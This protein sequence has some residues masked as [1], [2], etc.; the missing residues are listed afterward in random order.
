MWF[1]MAENRVHGAFSPPASPLGLDM[2]VPKVQPIGKTMTINHKGI[3][4]S[5][6]ES[7]DAAE[8]MWG[9]I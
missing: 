4:V 9:C 6:K 1:G 5:S 8:K 7:S 2:I 3:R